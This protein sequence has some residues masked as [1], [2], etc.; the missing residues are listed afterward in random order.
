MERDLRYKLS[1]YP[2]PKQEQK[3]WE[4]DQKINDSGVL[5]DMQLVENA[6]TCDESCQEKYFQEAQ[7]LTG[8]RTRAQ[9]QL[10]VIV[11][12]LAKQ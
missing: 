11:K 4:L 6:I 3:I 2:I 8:L 5:V 7:K 9:C 1:R 10:K 12:P